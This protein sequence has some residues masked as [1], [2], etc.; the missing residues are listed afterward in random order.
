MAKLL[1]DVNNDGQVNVADVTALVNMLNTGNVNYNKVADV[2]GNGLVNNNDVKALVNFILGNAP[3]PIVLNYQV[4][5][6]PN[7]NYEPIMIDVDQRICDAFGLT[8]D[9]I[10]DKV[11][12][13]FSS[14][15][16]DGCIMLYNY[17]DDGTFCT[18]NYNVGDNTPGYWLNN[19]GD[20]RYWSSDDVVGAVCFSK[21]NKKFF[22]YQY[23]NRIE[24]GDTMKY[25][26]GLRYNNGGEMTTV[27][28]TFNLTFSNEIAEDI[29]TLQ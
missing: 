29:V 23:P 8:V 10:S 2:D 21:D 4:K 5:A 15:V 14:V 24:S 28:L 22:I 1:G 18:D 16:D 6:K 9:Q 3:T 20:I 26:F 17:N 11:Q 19:V 13:E 25:I 12:C 27:G 7:N